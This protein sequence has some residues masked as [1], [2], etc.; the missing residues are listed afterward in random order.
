MLP[1]FRHQ[2]QLLKILLHIICK[3]KFVSSYTYLMPFVLKAMFTEMPI[4]QK[5]S[6]SHDCKLNV[7]PVLYEWLPAT[8]R[9]LVTAGH[10]GDTAF[11]RPMCG[12]RNTVQSHQL[13]V[14]PEKHRI[15]PKI[16][17]TFFLKLTVLK[18]MCGLKSDVQRKVLKEILKSPKIVI[19]IIIIGIEVILYKD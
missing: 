1:C 2:L 15:C 3:S 4:K 8:L 13:Q 17:C 5:L 14:P 19:I 7:L 16:G 10:Q 6:R 18:P 12:S 9:R 11:V